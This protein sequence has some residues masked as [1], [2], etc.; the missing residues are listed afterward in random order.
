M[1]EVFAA[2][3]TRLDRRVAIKGLPA[4][5]LGD[6]IARERLRREA[7]ATAALDDPF[8]CKVFELLDDPSGIF[9]VM[10]F[11]DGETLH[12]RLSAGP[13]PLAEGLRIAAEIAEALG[14]AHARE[15]VHRDL[16]PS[17][18]MLTRQGRTKVMDFGLAR[19][20]AG[21]RETMA[22]AA[23]QAP[24][25]DQGM[26]V[27]TPDY[28]SPE[29]ALGDD[30]D[31]RSDLFA[32]GILLCEMLAGVHPFRRGTSGSTLSAI[33]REEPMFAAAAALPPAVQLILRRLLAKSPAERYQ[34]I[35]D[36]RRDLAAVTT[37]SAVA[38]AVEA[39]GR[40]NSRFPLVGRASERAELLRGLDAALSGQGSIAM[41]SGEPGIGKTRLT[42][43]ILTEA[44][45]RGCFCLVGHCYEMEGAPPYVPF[46]E[47]LE[48]SARS[49]PPA[50]FRQ[51]LGD[52]ASAVSKLMPEL[53]RI[54]PDVA[55]PPELPPEQ[56]R[57]YLFNAYLEF[58]ERSC[59]TTP[60]AVVLED[61]HW[62]DEPTLML[63]QHL[64]QAAASLPLFIMATYRDVELGVTRPFARTLETLLR[65]RRA[66]RLA[67]R[68]LPREAVQTML[69]SMSGH[70]PPPSF[71][72]VIFE[73]TEG[74]PF[75]VEEVFQH[76]AE[77][78]RLFDGDGRWRQDLQVRSLEVPESVRLVIGRRLERLGADARS[79]LATAAVI[80]RTFSLQ[81]LES[82]HASPD[83]A[84]DAIEEA[85]RAQLVVAEPRGR[86]TR[87]RFAHEL[88][89]QT[90]AETLS[91][92]RR[93]RQHARIAEAIERLYAPGLDRHVLAL[94]HHLYQAGTAAAPEKAAAYLRQAAAQARAACGF[95]E[96]L[97][98]LDNALSL[99]EGEDTSIV[100]SLIAE[101][102]TVCRSL[103][104]RAEAIAGYKRA[105]DMH[106]RLKDRMAAATV[107]L[108]LVMAQIWEADN[109]AAFQ[110]AQQNLLRAG[111]EHDALHCRVLLSNALAL[112]GLGRAGEALDAYAEV[113][114]V[115]CGIADPQLAVEMQL[116]EIHIQWSAMHVARATELARELGAGAETAGNDYLWAE[117]K[118]IEGSAYLYTG[119]FEKAGHLFNAIL[120]RAERAG[121]H[122]VVWICQSF[123]SVLRLQ[124]GDLRGA[125]TEALKARAIGEQHGVVWKFFDDHALGL[126]ALSEGDSETAARHLVRALD[127]Q[128]LTYWRGVT[129]SHMAFHRAW[130]GDIGAL[131]MLDRI[132]AWP[133][134]GGVAPAGAWFALPLGVRTLALLGRTEEVARLVPAA[135]ALVE[136][137][138]IAHYYSSQ[139]TAGIAAAAARNWNASEDLHRQAIEHVDN[140]PFP[141]AQ[142]DTREW[143][144]RMLMERDG[145]GDADR[146]RE[147]LSEAIAQYDAMGMVAFAGRAAKLRAA[148]HSPAPWTNQKP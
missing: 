78:G 55:P 128:P 75:F 85:E 132:P 113:R 27:G 122:N 127:E 80:G 97:A 133:V 1:G 14:T 62:A 81:L 91:M 56:Q 74:N 109:R 61:L 66:T 121:H 96:A 65:E 98:H 9:I 68:R 89:R 76:L 51:A 5:L 47:M 2:Q 72:R 31:P 39:T 138:L 131:E 16:K 54:F 22:G 112:A 19:Q 67:L 64:A 143:Y 107:A 119:E 4:P 18:V 50:T 52:A 36:V 87:Y 42:L 129:E 148:I 93:Q 41:I 7:L 46:V 104:R 95:E 125:R 99:W 13:L 45:R 140:L 102:A 145:S 69:E 94:A 12:Q 117:V 134:P 11:V 116:A 28:M 146:A 79:M 17:N 10:E 34:K 3:D 137:G 105:L 37:I 38:P 114:R 8:I 101:R 73:E 71:A 63:L 33:V 6:P 124:A 115:A 126:I 20:T 53:R 43:D 59:R 86:E 49:V 130:H 110:S 88:I 82:L 60:L 142:P 40:G 84:L 35:A 77:E 57:R 21:A 118:W 90:L 26:R 103:G 120:P 123:L 136:S 58:V 25:T 32:F 15:L 135:L 111:A 108:E 106:D 100:A 24:L 92:P 83:A 29:Q 141:I 139:T 44:R 144:G 30:P 147:L 23:T 48:Y 70:P